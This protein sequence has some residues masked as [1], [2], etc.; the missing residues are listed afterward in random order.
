LNSKTV[1]KLLLIMVSIIRNQHM[2]LSSNSLLSEFNNY[3]YESVGIDVS[4]N[5]AGYG[6]TEAIQ[7]ITLDLVSKYDQADSLNIIVSHNHPFTVQIMREPNGRCCLIINGK[8]DSWNSTNRSV[9]SS[10]DNVVRVLSNHGVEPNPAL[11][12]KGVQDG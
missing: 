6:Y 8:D 11:L 5:D 4:L 1:A 7:F 3:G 9:H 10:L 2:A 12:S